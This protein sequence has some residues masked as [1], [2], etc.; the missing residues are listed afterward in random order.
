MKIKWALVVIAVINCVLFNGCTKRPSEDDLFD[1]KVKSMFDEVIVSGKGFQNFV[2]N[3]PENTSLAELY[4]EGTELEM[5]R[6]SRTF[7]EVDLDGDGVLEVVLPLAMGNSEYPHGFE[8]LHY[9]GLKIVG[10]YIGLRGLLNLKADASFTQ[11][12]GIYDSSICSIASFEEN[13][14]SIQ[15]IA[16]CE[17]S[18][19][20]YGITTVRYYINGVEANE[21]NFY[22]MA[23]KQATKADI[24]FFPLTDY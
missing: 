5:V 21:K 1:T 22:D 11:S 18:V 23:E 14:Y 10:Y 20:E 3:S 7:A 13:G 15:K 6:A 9:D 8:I 19:D 2:N 24:V 16:W 12:A 17:S 4:R